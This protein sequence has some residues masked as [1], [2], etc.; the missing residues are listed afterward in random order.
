LFAGTDTE[1]VAPVPVSAFIF[2]E[3]EEMDPLYVAPSLTRTACTPLTLLKS[4]VREPEI[5]PFTSCDDASVVV[6]LDPLEPHAD[7]PTAN[8][9]SIKIFLVFMFPLN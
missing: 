5:T 1:N 7:S 9:R 6:P 2:A 4:P 3:L 8:A